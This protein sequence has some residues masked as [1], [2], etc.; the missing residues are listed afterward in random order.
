MSKKGVISN[1]DEIRLNI[2]NITYEMVKKYGITHTSIEKITKACGI[3]KG[4]FYHYFSSKE[5]LILDLIEKQGKDS[6]RHFQN[7]LNGREKMSR[8]EGKDY[9]RFVITR[10]D[11]I[12]R[13]LTREY[14]QK[15]ECSFPNKAED[16]HP[17][18][19]IDTIR[20]LFSRIDGI[21]PDV[22]VQL[23]ADLITTYS[24]AF[25]H[26]DDR[27]LRPPRA[28]IEDT[29]YSHLFSLIFIDE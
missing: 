11:T 17:G 16:I 18:Q 21:R 5:A 10:D 2:L 19:R 12:Y 27:T 24:V 13:H 26:W 20:M 8:N 28:E 25:F 29:L 6:F 14:L 7:L 23:V 1:R 15:L 9:I 3:G 22:N 4:T